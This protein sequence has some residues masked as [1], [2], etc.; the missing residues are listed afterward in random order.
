M[1]SDSMEPAMGTDAAGR[2]AEARNRARQGRRHPRL[3][4]RFASPSRALCPVSRRAA[5]LTAF[6]WSR[7]LGMRVQPA[8][9]VIAQAWECRSMQPSVIDCLHHCMMFI[10]SLQA[11]VG[12]LPDVRGEPAAQAEGPAQGRRRGQGD[13]GS[14]CSLL[15]LTSH[16]RAPW[17]RGGMSCT[18]CRTPT[19]WW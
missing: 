7:V 8:S 12:A 4:R 6:A 16:G 9:A 2:P 3:G 5:A 19:R 15:G 13:S 17:G 14:G 10:L 18:S 1:A 11:G